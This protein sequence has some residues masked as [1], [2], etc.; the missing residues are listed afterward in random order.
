[1]K[2]LNCLINLKKK[3]SFGIYRVA[4][5]FCFTTGEKVSLETRNNLLELL[6]YDGVGN[7][8]IVTS[9]SKFIEHQHLLN[10]VKD[11]EFIPT[12]AP[13]VKSLSL[14]TTV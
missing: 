12:S 10:N 11:L 4:K 13:S 8:T 7:D 2:H 1:M 3:V 9:R 6:S 14:G 5:I